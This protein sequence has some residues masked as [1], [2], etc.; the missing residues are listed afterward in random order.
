MFRCTLLVAGLFSACMPRG[1]LDDASAGEAAAEGVQASTGGATVSTG[2]SPVSGRA[3]DGGRSTGGAGATPSGGR[4]GSDASSSGGNRSLPGTGGTSN[5][6]G[7]GGDEPAAGSH[8]GPPTGGV[9]PASGG[10]GSAGMSSGSGGA[11]GSAAGASS[12]GSAAGASSGGSAAGASSGGSAA[13]AS[14][15]GAS[16]GRGGRDAVSL[17]IDLPNTPLTGTFTVSSDATWEVDGVFVPTF[18]IHTPTASYWLVKSLGVIV[19]MVDRG[20]S[21][22]RQW[23]DFSSSFRPLR[24]LPSLGT[25]EAPPSMTC[26]IDEDSQTPTHLRVPC[27]TSSKSWRLVWDF[28]PTHVTLT[29]NAAPTPFGIAYRGVPG[30][31]LDETDRFVSASGAEQSAITSSVTDWPGDAEWA[32]VSDP[33]LGRSLFAIHHADDELTD[34]YQVKDNDSALISF[35]DGML[36]ALPQRF[37][38]GLVPSA[39]HAAV[40]DRADFVIG[41]IR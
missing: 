1:D 8:A 36:T 18:E 16:A 7:S 2:G 35:G 39:S 32:Y 30:G 4:G 19:S 25:F 14:S 26:A 3:G 22:T 38:F 20:A 6:A 9:G 27:A 23:I 33:V 41:A 21:N 15:G 11:G 40:K 5:S 12:G 29:V 17:P 24:G 10:S 28:Y 31:S 34:R 13:G 37:S